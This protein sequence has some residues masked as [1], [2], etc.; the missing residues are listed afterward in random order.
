MD[1]TTRLR[2]ILEEASAELKA[3]IRTAPGGERLRLLRACLFDLEKTSYTLER[4]VASG[5]GEVH[6]AGSSAG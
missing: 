5:A 4:G 2:A 1:E 3:L 6:G